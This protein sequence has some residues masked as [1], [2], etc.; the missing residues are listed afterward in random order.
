MSAENFHPFSHSVN[1]RETY[2]LR[3]N[4]SSLKNSRYFNKNLSL[5]FLVSGNFFVSVH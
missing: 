2:F 3:Q 5:V 1:P 4:S